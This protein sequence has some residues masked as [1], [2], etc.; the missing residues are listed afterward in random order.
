MA[1]DS[2]AS[3]LVLTY[4]AQLDT[5][6][7]LLDRP[8]DSS[9]A[10]GDRPDALEAL[11]A[12]ARSLG[13]RVQLGALQLTTLDAVCRSVAVLVGPFQE[14]L[15]KQMDF[16]R[17]F[18]GHTKTKKK[19]KAG[20]MQ[21]LKMSGDPTFRGKKDSQLRRYVV[22]ASALLC[23]PC[24]GTLKKALP[25]LLQL[26]VNQL[27]SVCAL[28]LEHP[29]EAQQRL[30][31]VLKRG[32][33]A[34][35]DRSE[36]Q[37]QKQR[38]E[39]S[40]DQLVAPQASLRKRRRSSARL[41]EQQEQDR[42]E[43]SMASRFSSPSTLSSLT[44]TSSHQDARPRKTRRTKTRQAKPIVLFPSLKWVSLAA[45]PKGKLRPADHQLLLRIAFTALGR[46]PTLDAVGA[47]SQISG[48]GLQ[49]DLMHDAFGLDRKLVD[50]IVQHW[51]AVPSIAQRLVV[52]CGR[53]VRVNSVKVLISLP[54]TRPQMWHLDSRDPERNE[55]IF[56]TMLTEGHAATQVRDLLLASG[57]GRRCMALGVLTGLCLKIFRLCSASDCPRRGC[58][59]PGASDFHLRIVAQ[60]EPTTHSSSDPDTSLPS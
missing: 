46:L 57:V 5:L 49:L 19:G 9:S 11:R 4:R 13:E 48:P 50:G 28:W 26:G 25:V 45:H 39:R 22:I 55:L 41:Q 35:A 38:E 51:K 37:P 53:R 21:L 59:L 30:A 1:T 36:D 17:E 58:I 3:G 12:R 54:G 23:F 34:A 10:S 33:P 7:A 56:V 31:D 16:P 18:G 15:R 8:E 27:A 20:L 42:P 52:V 14:A 43:T 32:P 29:E 60:R 40:E 44:S 24:K 47:V 6:H 2:F